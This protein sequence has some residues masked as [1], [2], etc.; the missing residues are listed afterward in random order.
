MVGGGAVVGDHG[1]LGS[2]QTRLDGQPLAEAL[3]GPGADIV[4]HKKLIY[5]TRSS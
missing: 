4:N 1:G 3:P 2:G 5:I